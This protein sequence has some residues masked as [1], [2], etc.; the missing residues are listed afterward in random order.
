MHV[1]IPDSLDK[2]VKALAKDRF[3]SAS[4]VVEIAV[5]AY[6]MMNGIAPSSAARRTNP[7]RK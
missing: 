7:K 2:P 6:L 3:V 1:R 5:R 4:K